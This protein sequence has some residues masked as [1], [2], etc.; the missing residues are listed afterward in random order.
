MTVDDHQFTPAG[1]LLAESRRWVSGS[2]Q[3]RWR[4]PAAAA[5]VRRARVG[6]APRGG[7]ATT[8][9]GTTEIAIRVGG[10]EL[11]LDLQHW[12]NDGWMAFFFFVVGLEVKRELVPG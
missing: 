6:E 4:G 12:V 8:L 5:T 11:A 9:S 2:G 3:S 7:T 10:A 1:G